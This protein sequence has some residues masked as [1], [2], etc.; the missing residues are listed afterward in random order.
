MGVAA[1]ATLCILEAIASSCTGGEP[2]QGDAGGAPADGQGSNA[3]GATNDVK[4]DVVSSASD[5]GDAK[6]DVEMDSLVDRV[7]GMADADADVAQSMGDAD[8]DV[9]QSMGDADA[10]VAQSMGDADADVAQSVGDA[11][12]SDVVTEGETSTSGIILSLAGQD[13]LNCANA[14]SDVGSSCLTQFSCE[15]LSGQVSGAGQ[16]RE[17]L[18]FQTLECILGTN[19]ASTVLLG[20]Y[21]GSASTSACENTDAANGSCLQEEQAGLETTNPF[22]ITVL[23]FYDTSLG[24]AVANSLVQCLKSNSCSCFE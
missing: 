6:H 14:A 9:A 5:A 16:S 23:D 3:D 21:C 17:G 24:G 1:A 2:G 10:D 11:D 13:C 18:C 4:S 8:A 19:C 20:C 22:Y 15:S 12:A 7:D